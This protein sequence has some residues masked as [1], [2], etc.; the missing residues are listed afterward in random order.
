MELTWSTFVLEIINF[1]VLVWILKR[2]L[3]KPIMDIIEKRRQ[4]IDATL[5]DAKKLQADAEA[6]QQ[7]YETRLSTWEAEKRAQS[8]ALQASIREQKTQ[9]LEQLKRDID[10]EREKQA[11]IVAQQQREQQLRSQSDA[12]QLGL[13]FTSRLLGSLA[14]PALENQLTDLLLEQL[15]SLPAEQAER[16][17]QSCS[18][19]NPS[20]RVSSAHPLDDEH[21]Q[22]IEQSLRALCAESATIDFT[23][24]HALLAGLRICTGNL[25]LRL[26]LQ[27]ELADF[28]SVASHV[29]D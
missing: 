28:A 18:G 24:D 8:E 29:D 20:I 10:N 17:R 22:R 7:Q 23:T 5:A 26:N 16:L 2:F 27:D 25:I 14:T 4:S 13:R 1:L 19:T 12:M 11:A 9:L 3:Y 15:E 21:R 6:M